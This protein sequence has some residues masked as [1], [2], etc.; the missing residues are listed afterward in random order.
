MM[1]LRLLAVAAVI[2]ALMA[3]MMLIAPGNPPPVSQVWP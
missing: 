1:A 3:G 2:T